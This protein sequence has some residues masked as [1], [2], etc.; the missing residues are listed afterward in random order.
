MPHTLFSQPSSGETAEPLSVTQLVGHLKTL[1]ETDYGHV[2]VE[3]ELSNFSRARSGHCYFSVKDEEAQLECVMWRR[4]TGRVRFTPEDGMLVRLEGKVSIYEQRGKLQLYADTMRLAGEGAL[5]KAFEKLKKRL[6]REGLFDEERKRPLPPFPE[7]I[8]LVTSGESAALQDLLTVL[9]RR[10]PCVQVQLRPVAVQGNGAGEEIAAAINAFSKMDAPPDLLIVG[11]G[12]GSA[13]DLWAF[14]EEVVARALHACTIPVVSAVGHETDLSIADLVADRRAATPSMG[15]E[16]AVPDRRDVAE[17]VHALH[18]ALEAFATTRL[19]EGRAAVRSLV[20]SRGFHRPVDRLRQLQQ[21]LDTLTE[22][23]ERSAPR[24]VERERQRLA[25]LQGQLAALD[26]RGPLRRGYAFVEHDG[27][28]VR[29]AE[30]L[31]EDAGVTLTFRDGK[32]K[33]RI[34]GEEAA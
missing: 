18:E 31:A 27:Q 3:G 30:A 29:A 1:V 24:L 12:G 9:R 17:T 20:Q 14:N 33:A 22:R 5:Q 11:R 13:E 32:R 16:V 34:T 8:G 23:L 6:R 28:P 26:P 10:F 4:A 21:R 19:Q 7:T 25:L 2:T 15:A